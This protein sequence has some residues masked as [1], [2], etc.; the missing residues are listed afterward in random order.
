MSKINETNNLYNTFKKS[1][2]SGVNGAGAMTVQVCTLMWMRTIMNHQYRY[3]NSIK[4]TV[5]TLYNNGGIRRFYR[6]IG[7]ALLQGPASRFGD[8]FSNTFALSLCK[9]NEFLKNAPI[10]VQTAFASV[11]AGSFRI[12]LMPIDTTKTIL[13]VE[14]KN[15]LSILKNKLKLGG[16]RILFNGSLATASATMIGHYPWFMTFNY[17]DNYLPKYDKSE[18]LYT[19]GRNALIGFS[20]SVVSDTL[21][22]SLRVIKTT[23]QSYKTN[24]SYI[25][26]IKEIIEKDGIKGLFGRGLT[27]RLATNGIQGLMFSVIWKYLDS[28]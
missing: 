12:L 9:N 21:S 25:N 28:K 2:T 24:I 5:N 8:T 14:G 3:G 20:A 11:T 16:P 23:K 6:G 22:N 7:P 17:L 18:K 1:I 19:F 15:G 4:Y 13:Q 27:I 26:I 10:F